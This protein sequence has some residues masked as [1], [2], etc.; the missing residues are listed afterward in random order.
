[1][2]TPKAIKKAY[3]GGVEDFFRKYYNSPAFER[4]V[5][6]GEST[7]YNN[8][9][10]SL[11]KELL[12]QINNL[13]NT[14]D[15]RT[16]T[17]YSGGTVNMGNPDGYLNQPADGVYAHEVSHAGDNKII[18]VTPRQSFYMLDKDD[19]YKNWAADAKKAGGSNPIAESNEKI[20]RDKVA[21]LK[22]EMVGAWKGGDKERPKEILKEYNLRES[23]FY[24]DHENAARH[25][26]APGE[27]RGDINALRYYLA[28][29][30]IWDITDPKSGSFGADQ[31]KAMYQI[32][33][34][35]R[36]MKQNGWKTT[37]NKRPTTIKD[38]KGNSIPAPKNPGMFL[39][40]LRERFSDDELMWLINNVAKSNIDKKGSN[41]SEMA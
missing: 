24:D 5:K 28:K 15:K 39:D 27:I 4:N 25:D 38:S 7:W 17:W 3:M 19:A 9:I 21:T 41:E 1:M 26:S 16:S 10:P 11:R 14:Y 35:N 13:Q 33:D 22:S 23:G 8:D 36:D 34:L 2:A 29:N 18:P 20:K 31:L 12:S 37:P 30:G 32:P 6:S 40:R